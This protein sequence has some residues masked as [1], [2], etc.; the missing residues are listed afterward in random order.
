MRPRDATVLLSTVAI[1]LIGCGNGDQSE[2]HRAAPR[3]GGD[4]AAVIRDWADTLRRG[5]V[6]G[7]AELFALPSIVSNGTPPIEL[8]TRAAARL[9]NASLPC[10]ARLIRTS[11]A[12]RYTTAVF[13]LTERPGP[14]SCG[15]GTGLTAR[16]S[17]V[18][19]G[20]K[21]REWRRVPDRPEPSRPIVQRRVLSMRA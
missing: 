16:T 10:G 5:D 13:R 11:S 19:S 21:I 4:A 17:F 1:A 7:A 20:G 6:R 12:G 15:Q 3:T 8:R 14:G 9:F 18:I 2:Q